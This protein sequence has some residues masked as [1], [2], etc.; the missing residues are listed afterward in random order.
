MIE[1]I[2]GAI[3]EFF[4][5]YVF[6]WLFGGIYK[7]LKPVLKPL[8]QIVAFPFKVLGAAMK[9]I[10]RLGNQPFHTILK[11]D[12]NAQFALMVSFLGLFIFSIAWVVSIKLLRLYLTQVDFCHHPFE[13]SE[14]KKLPIFAIY[15]IQRSFMVKS[16]PTTTEKN[17]FYAIDQKIKE[18]L[19][20]WRSI[21]KPYQQSD[22]FKAIIQIINTFIP[23]L[24]IS[25]LMYLSLDVSFALV[26]LLGLIN[27][28]FL[29]RLFIIQHDCG[30]QS[31]FPSKTWNNRLGHICSFFTSIPF[32]YWARAHNF[33]HTHNGQLEHREVGRYILPHS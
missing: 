7:I 5:Y 10:I 31:F 11:E 22:N 13:Y 28:F 17:P 27:G 18:E 14:S 26:I 33:H 1:F 25:Y 4:A 16:H 6:G 20:N 9:W 32:K 3:L 19:K 21:I 24:A 2:F 30:H 8:I 12:Y 23:F 29:S 15:F